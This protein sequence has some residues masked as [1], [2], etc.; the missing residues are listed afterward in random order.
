VPGAITVTFWGT[1]H[2]DIES[3]TGERRNIR[4]P[5]VQD[6]VDDGNC[7][8][9]SG[10]LGFDIT[11]TRVFKDHG[12]GAQVRTENFNTHYA[13]E[14]IIHCIP[15]A[16][17]A[18]AAASPPATGATTAPATPSGRRPG[19]RGTEDVRARVRRRRP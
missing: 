18:A 11:V 14:A 17:P 3:V 2:Y 6:K 4:Q 13:A 12:S 5:A 8:P 15:P 9:Q 10:S 16:D 19:A 1:K 7:T